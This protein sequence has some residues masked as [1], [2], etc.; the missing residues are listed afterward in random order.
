MHTVPHQPRAVAAGSAPDRP[1]AATPAVPVERPDRQS[2]AHEDDAIRIPRRTLEVLRGLMP[3]ARRHR[4]WFLPGAVAALM[5]IGA[6]LALPWPLRAVADH[7]TGTA[8]SEFL[9]GLVPAAFDPV[10]AMGGLFL[11]LVFVLGFSDYLQRTSFARFAGATASDLRA[12]A[13]AGAFAGATGARSGY[14]GANAGELVTRFVADAPRIRSGMQGFLVHVATSGVLIAG[15]TA[16]LLRMD[17]MLGAVFLL[18]GL[19]TLAVTGWA[20]ARIF[21]HTLRQQRSDGDLANHIHAALGHD[22]G[23]GTEVAPLPRSAG[24]DTTRTH[25]QGIATW[26]THAIFGAAILAALAIASSAVVARSM[27]AGDLVVFL[28]YALMLHSPIVRLARQ[29]SKTGKVLGAT[30]R[31][32]Q[33]VPEKTERSSR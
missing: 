5:V 9:L 17:A 28:M 18:A 3:F 25:L 15:M 8:G 24:M 21:R 12:S 10:L 1:F 11:L 20:A 13:I 22:R 23:E 32:L 2:A 4:R 29:G 19:G 7:A 6:R 31:L 16:V 33:F 14:A 26:A 27:S 30:H